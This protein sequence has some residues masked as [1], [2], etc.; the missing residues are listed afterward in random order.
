MLHDIK[1]IIIYV[2]FIHCCIT[3]SV[4]YIFLFTGFERQHEL[5]QFSLILTEFGFVS[6]IYHKLEKL[7]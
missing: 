5:F 1:S 7:E 4:V 6:T 2:K 3:V